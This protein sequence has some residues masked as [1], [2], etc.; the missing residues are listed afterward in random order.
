MFLVEQSPVGIDA[1]PL[2]DLRAHLRLGTGFADDSVQDSALAGALKA[3]IAQIEALTGKAILRRG[4]VY[5]VNAWR[6]VGRQVLPRAPLGAVT[7]IAIIRSDGSR[8]VLEPVAVHVQH[9]THCPSIVA[10]SFALPSIPVGGRAEITFTAGFADDWQDVPSDLSLAVLSLAAALYE[11]RARP[12]EMP[13][14]IRALISPYRQP[15]FLR[16]FG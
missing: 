1:L 3:A 16:A 7:E 5:T 4:F 13:R 6:G 8:Q 14:G 15:R 12:G 11:D 10:K 9:D 2:S